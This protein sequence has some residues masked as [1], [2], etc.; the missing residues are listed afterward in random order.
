[1]SFR[2][3]KCTNVTREYEGHFATNGF[4]ICN[5]AENNGYD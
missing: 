3:Y 1:M 2:I 4:F 5:H